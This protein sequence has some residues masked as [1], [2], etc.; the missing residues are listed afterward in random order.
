MNNSGLVLTFIVI[1]FN[2]VF[3]LYRIYLM[4][5]QL[6]NVLTVAAIANCRELK[7]KITTGM[8]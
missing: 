5:Q 1:L 4:Y 6:N 8:S 7:M 2:L 3:Y